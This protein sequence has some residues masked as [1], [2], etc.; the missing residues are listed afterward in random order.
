MAF[1]PFGK[2]KGYAVED[3]PDAYVAW[4]VSIDLREPLRGAVVDEM[5]RRGLGRWPTERAHALAGPP[6]EL[7]EPVRSLI[8]TGFRV[9]VTWP[10]GVGPTP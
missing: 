2:F 9:S 3:L 10:R 6:P 1:M 7:R 4:L 8:R 5:A